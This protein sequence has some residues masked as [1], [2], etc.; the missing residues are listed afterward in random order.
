MRV[1]HG[2]PRRRPGLRLPGRRPARPRAAT[3]VTVEGLADGRAARTRC[4]RRSSTPA[5]CS[6]GSAR[7]GWSSPCT[8]C[9][10]RDRR[11]DR[12]RRS[13]RRWPGTSAAAPATRRS[14]TRSGWPR[15]AREVRD[16]RCVIEGCAVA[17]VDDAGHGVRRRARRGRRGPDRRGRARAPPHPTSSRMRDEVVD[18]TRLPG[19]PRPGQ[20]PP[21][22]LPVGHPGLAQQ[23]DLFGWLTT[24]Y[25]VWE[26][27]DEDV[28]G[29]AAAAGLGWLARSG[30]TT[31]TDHHYVFP[32]DGGDVLAAHG[33]RPPARSACGSTRPAGRWTSG[34]AGA[35]CR[36][37]PSWRRPRPRWPRT[38]GPSTRYHDPA[39]GSML[40]MA[41][42]AVLA[43]LG[44]RA[45]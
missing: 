16:D 6:A 39:P 5:P 33:R 9:S 43:V 22:P 36:R 18:G 27:L 38:R 45:T 10:Q 41:R 29:A 23:D 11:P 21:P 14:S 19:H 40:R 13:A 12:R 42:R 4:S 28:V 17:T 44:D 1:L 26:G 3:V 31:T 15:R 30:C 25:P 32:R 7:R 24:L 35:G 37:T 34:R 2:L 20:H 8:T